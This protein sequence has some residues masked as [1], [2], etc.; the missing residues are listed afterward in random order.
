ML[1]LVMKGGAYILK[2]MIDEQTTEGNKEKMNIYSHI[3]NFLIKE[4]RIEAD[5]TAKKS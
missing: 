3:I 1:E 4:A 5:I 2:M